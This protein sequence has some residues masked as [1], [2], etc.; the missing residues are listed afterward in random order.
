MEGLN[1]FMATSAPPPDMLVPEDRR[2]EPLRHA[3][4][5]RPPQRGMCRSWPDTLGSRPSHSL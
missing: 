4:F 1:S 5:P 2:C 3:L